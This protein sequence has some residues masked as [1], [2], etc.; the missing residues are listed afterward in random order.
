MGSTLLLACH[1]IVTRRLLLSIS[2]AGGLHQGAVVEIYPGDDLQAAVAASPPGT[3]FALKRGVHRLQQII[4]KGGNRFVGE[5]D[6]V[7]SGA[8]L[9]TSFARK[10]RYW[11]AEHQS[12]HGKV[13][14]RC[15]AGRPRCNHPEDL[16]LDDLPLVHAAS[17][18]EVQ[19]GG[20]FFDYAADA[21]YLADDP[22]GHRVETSVARCAFYGAIRDVT[23][24]GLVIEKYANPAQTGAVDG[25]GSL[26]WIVEENDIRLN[27][28]VGILTGDHMLV[29]RN[30]IHHQG[31][32]GIG[33]GG[34]AVVLEDN[35]I[36]FNN[37][38]GYSW[39]WEAGGTKL[40]YTTGLIVR[41]NHSHH[42]RGP[43]L[44]TDIDNL[45]TTYEGNRVEDNDGAGIDH[46][47]SYAA[48]IRNNIIARNGWGSSNHTTWPEGSGILINSS[49]DVEIAGNTLMDNA[50]GI[51]LI[52]S[53]RGE[54][55]Y[56]PHIVRNLDAHDNSITQPA[57]FTGAAQDVGNAAVFAGRNIRFRRNRYVLRRNGVPF[58]W[59]GAARTVAEWREYGQD[60]DGSFTP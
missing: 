24:R 26:G 31:Q 55:L 41:R 56:G 21:I 37:T 32:L 4:P 13:H 14:G 43:G 38:A 34:V 29:S 20:W 46:E 17:L 58:R 40:A 30:R 44:W 42:N 18:A 53:A 16:F 6:A 36:A 27:H 48:I 52:Q 45:R 47:I 59:S 9:L 7:L 51:G 28:G 54:G 57:G 1:C 22:T 19:P 39:Y 60:V 12:Q 35:E 5:P 49:P 50:N 25:R 10:G 8:A 23:I 11:V 33:G 2:L 3:T 15:T